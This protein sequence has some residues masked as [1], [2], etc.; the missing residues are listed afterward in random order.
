M[1]NSFSCPPWLIFSR[2]TVLECCF[3]KKFKF[4][5]SD[6]YN[7]TVTTQLLQIMRRRQ[8][9]QQPAP[10]ST[11]PFS[12]SA[13]L[14]QA[15][16][17]SSSNNNIIEESSLQRVVNN[18][19]KDSSTNISSRCSMASFDVISGASDD[20]RKPTSLLPRNYTGRRQLVIAISC[21]FFILIVLQV[22]NDG[23]N[24]CSTLK[25]NSNARYKVSCVS[26]S[27]VRMFCVIL[28]C[29]GIGY[30]L[31]WNIC[32]RIVHSYLTQYLGL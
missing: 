17:T 19:R 3:Q 12:S 26:L 25:N 10:Q 21:F 7:K 9:A 24:K 5:V 15:T 4:F 14:E 32:L 2:Y 18:R 27:V 16:S 22:T 31:L 13:D 8:Q 28:G 6:S 29:L 20:E 1:K 30:M 23:K 11:E